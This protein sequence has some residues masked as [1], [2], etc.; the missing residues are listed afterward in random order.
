MPGVVTGFVKGRF[1]PPLASLSHFDP[2]LGSRRELESV[3]ALLGYREQCR[4]LPRALRAHT[5]PLLRV[6]VLK[7]L[8]LF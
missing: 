6:P 1:L 7:P 2:E 8:D 5:L 3:E 4:A